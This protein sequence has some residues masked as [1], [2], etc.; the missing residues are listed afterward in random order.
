MYK[1]LKPIMDKDRYS[2]EVQKAIEYVIWEAI[3]MPLF[4][5]LNPR[6]NAVQKNPI[7][8]AL[9]TEQIYYRDGY[10]YG[11]FSSEIG[12]A[13]RAVGATYDS[14]KKAY[15]VSLSNLSIELRSV[16]AHVK[17]T[18]EKKA[19]E[20]QKTLKEWMP[21]KVASF[22]FAPYV[23]KTIDD[24][25]VQFKKVT[26]KDLEI[27]MGMSEAQ[28]NKVTEDYSENLNL[29]ISGW[30]DT[31]V[32]RLREKVEAHV[33][34]GFRADKLQ[35]TIMSEYAITKSKAKFIARQETSLLV[36]KY[37]QTRYED[38]GINK[39]RWST[40]HD[41]RV[42]DDHKILDGRMFSFDQPPII[43]RASGMRGNPGE[44]YRCRCVALPVVIVA[45]EEVEI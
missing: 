38:A 25:N 1:Q 40:S 28:K 39:Y 23:A 24:L 2:T 4:A 14:R 44:G 3:F 13:L 34:E 43:D 33:A 19:F 32:M 30:S 22:D 45:G 36:S 26:P 21:E 16:M 10:F 12:R 35:E 6:E 18:A 29:S 27:P 17:A 8:K 11:K 15:K 20:V 37:R 9:L 7:T 42:R 31:A 5:I 41:E